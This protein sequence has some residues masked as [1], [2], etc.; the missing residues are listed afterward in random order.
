MEAYRFYVVEQLI[1]YE[2]VKKVG[3]EGRGAQIR[4]LMSQI[5]IFFCARVYYFCHQKILFNN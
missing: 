4:S 1:L 2:F 3:Y 5:R